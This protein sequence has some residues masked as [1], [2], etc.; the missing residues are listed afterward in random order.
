MSKPSSDPHTERL[1]G[2]SGARSN[3]NGFV[4]LRRGVRGRIRPVVPYQAISLT[5]PFDAAASVS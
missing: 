5:L 4:S 2:R 3:L 1:N